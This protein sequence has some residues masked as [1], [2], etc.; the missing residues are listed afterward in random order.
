MADRAKDPQAAAKNIECELCYE[1]DPEKLHKKLTKCFTK[2]LGYIYLCD[3]HNNTSAGHKEEIRCECFFPLGYYTVYDPMSCQG[4][5]H[6]GL[7]VPE[8]SCSSLEHWI[9]PKME[10]TNTEDSPTTTTICDRCGKSMQKS[11]IYSACCECADVYCSP[12][13]TTQM[14]TMFSKECE[15]GVVQCVCW[16]CD[17]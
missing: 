9:P 14:A 11:E 5:P 8:K 12:K 16:V 4:Q 1:R 6:S 10:K 2:T 13:C 17:D 3:H 15:N 7:P